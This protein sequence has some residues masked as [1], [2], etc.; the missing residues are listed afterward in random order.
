MSI[1]QKKKLEPVSD[2]LFYHRVGD[3]LKK[4]PLILTFA[5]DMKSYIVSN[6]EEMSAELSETL[7]KLIYGENPQNQL[8]PYTTIIDMQRRL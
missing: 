6:S 4:R 2:S 7:I 5:S 8:P 1:I 3:I